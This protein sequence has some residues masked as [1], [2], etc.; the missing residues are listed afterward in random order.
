MNDRKLIIIGLGLLAV[1]LVR[2]E[3]RLTEIEHKLDDIIYTKE[4]ITYTQADVECLTRNIYY[5]A[6]VEDYRGRVA[7]AQVT[8]NRLKTGR[9]GNTIC[10]VVYAPAQFSWTLKRRLERPNPAVWRECQEIALAVLQGK[11]MRGLQRSLYY[12]A[13][14]IPDPKWADPRHEVGQIG[15]H[16]FYN[17]AKNSQVSL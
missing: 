11:R 2:N 4:A 10:K 5:E 16:I 9:W 17:R 8:V 6:G 12:H 3:L 1:F 15:Q 13:T 7:V 14:Y